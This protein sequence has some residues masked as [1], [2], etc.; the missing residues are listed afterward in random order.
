[1][2]RA[3]STLLKCIANPDPGQG[4]DLLDGSRGRHARGRLRLPTPSCQARGGTSTSNGAILGMS[5]EGG[6]DSKL[7]AIGFSASNFINQPVKNYSSGMRAP[8]FSVSI[9]SRPDILVD[10]DS[11]RGRHGIPKGCMDKGSP[12]SRIRGLRSSS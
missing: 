9:T 10:E 3:K 6:I 7:D 11:G 12:S 1:M 2:V 8:G 4:L 5:K